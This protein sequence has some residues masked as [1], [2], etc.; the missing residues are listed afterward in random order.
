MSCCYVLVILCK[1]TRIAVSIAGFVRCH[2][3]QVRLVL[4]YRTKWRPEGVSSCQMHRA[5]LDPE[6]RLRPL[7]PCFQRQTRIETT[8]GTCPIYNAYHTNFSAL[9]IVRVPR[10]KHNERICVCIGGGVG[11]R[12]KTIQSLTCSERTYGVRR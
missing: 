6:S 10:I 12:A 7:N 3:I 5:V 9:R 8:T 11:T 2:L 4:Y 1:V